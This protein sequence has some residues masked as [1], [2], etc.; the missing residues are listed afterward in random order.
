MR[1]LVERERDVKF[2]SLV[3]ITKDKLFIL[4]TAIKRDG[5]FPANMKEIFWIGLK[6]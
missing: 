6:N 4:E 2:Q 5:K 3:E 1:L